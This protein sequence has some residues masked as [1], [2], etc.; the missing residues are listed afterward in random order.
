M[1]KIALICVIAIALFSCNQNPQS[2]EPSEEDY[3]S[4][5]VEKILNQS[6]TPVSRMT[7]EEIQMDSVYKSTVNL[8]NS[9]VDKYKDKDGGINDVW[10][11]SKNPTDKAFNRIR[12]CGSVGNALIIERRPFPFKSDLEVLGYTLSRTESHGRYNYF[13]QSSRFR[14]NEEIEEDRK[15]Q[16]IITLE[17]LVIATEIFH[18]RLQEAYE[19]LSRLNG[20]QENQNTIRSFQKNG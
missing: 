6:D 20:K 13:V 9:F 16:D 15:H 2:V 5:I 18:K 17:E 19:N 14:K 1:K 4:A 10:W 8:I 12:L 7:A 3:K 11:D